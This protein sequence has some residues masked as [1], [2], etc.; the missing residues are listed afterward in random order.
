MFERGGT[1]DGKRESTCTHQEKA[2]PNSGGI[3]YK[4]EEEEENDS[5]LEY[6]RSE[7]QQV[8]H[9]KL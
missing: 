6:V 4:E 1:H 8:A 2:K 7:Q 9:L 5:Q 3:P